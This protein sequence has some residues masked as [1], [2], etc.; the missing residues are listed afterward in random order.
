[1]NIVGAFVEG[2]SRCQRYLFSTLQLHRSGA[3]QYVNKSLR[4]RWIGSDAPGGYSTVIIRTSLP[5]FSPRS[6]DMSEVTF[7]C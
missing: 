1:M 7:A 5:G 2:L 3:L 4:I 6:F